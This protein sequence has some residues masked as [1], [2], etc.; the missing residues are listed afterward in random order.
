MIQI[1][2]SAWN[3]SGDNP[4]LAPNFRE[5]EFYHK[6]KASNHPEMHDL[7][8]LIPDAAQILRDY[9]GEPLRITSTLRYPGDSYYNDTSQHNYQKARAFDSQFTNDRSYIMPRYHGEILYRGE[10][11][12]LLYSLGVRGFGLYDTFIHLPM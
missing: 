9:Y 11:F 3:G 2:K 4:L 1:R 10:L 5:S 8:A 6:G 12:E 7:H